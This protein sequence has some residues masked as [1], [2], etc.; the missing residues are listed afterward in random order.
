[1]EFKPGLNFDP[2]HANQYIAVIDGVQVT[3]RFAAQEDPYI[4]EA[5]KSLLT[6]AY[7]DRLQRPA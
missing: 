6:T 4:K 3:V 7:K 5:I 2:V 1:M